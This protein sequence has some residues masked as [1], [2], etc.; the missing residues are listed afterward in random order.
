MVIRVRKVV[1]KT[2]SVSAVCLTVLMLLT[3][4]GAQEAETLPEDAGADGQTAEAEESAQT[5]P[6]EEIISS[7]ITIDFPYPWTQ[8]EF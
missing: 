7:R 8:D 6:E 1:Q 2:I 4:C 3:A 5:Q